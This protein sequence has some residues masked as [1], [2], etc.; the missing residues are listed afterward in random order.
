MSDAADLYETDFMRWAEGQAQALRAARA[1]GSNL[2]LDWDNL[3]E[4]VDGLARSQRRELR[5]RLDTI[6]EHLLK[7]RF[8]PASDPRPGWI[9]TVERER[10]EIE[11]L[12][13]DNRSLRSE[14]ASLVGTESGRVAKRV[15][16]LLVG[17]GEIDSALSAQLRAT[18]FS[19]DE[20]LA[21]RFPDPPAA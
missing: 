6:I 2:P 5:S 4:E 11:A 12:L 13:A 20:V 9:D 14:V 16:T 10:G 21:D 1:A 15:A 18:S 17:L 3:V 8:S 19:E 7:L